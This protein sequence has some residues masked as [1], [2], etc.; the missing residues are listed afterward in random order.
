MGDFPFKNQDL[1]L[2]PLSLLVVGLLF[3][4]DIV[5]NLIVVIGSDISFDTKSAHYHLKNYQ[6][7]KDLQ[8][9][10]IGFREKKTWGCLYLYYPCNGV[11]VR[12]FYNIN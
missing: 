1:V 4:S 5:R 11:F 7:V 3:L 10:L 12:A 2:F 8:Y 9:V 6:E